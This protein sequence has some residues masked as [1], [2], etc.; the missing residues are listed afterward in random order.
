[1]AEATEVQ[2]VDRVLSKQEVARRLDCSERN[3]DRL[4]QSGALAVIE[5][6]P[7]R[8]GVLQSDLEA[9]WLARRRRRGVPVQEV[10][11]A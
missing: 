4:F 7:R 11:A 3:V 10:T 5:I 6:S 2:E 9:F 8:V 1:M